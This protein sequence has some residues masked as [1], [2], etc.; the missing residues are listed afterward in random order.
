MHVGGRGRLDTSYV[1]PW[2]VSTRVFTEEFT[3]SI[4]AYAQLVH[5]LHTSYYYAY[6]YQPE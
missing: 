3:A 6:A 1:T 5:T 2:E 4:Y